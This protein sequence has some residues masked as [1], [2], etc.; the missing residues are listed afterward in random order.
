[1]RSCDGEAAIARLRA[2]PFV[3]KEGANYKFRI[4]FRVQHEIV[5]GLKFIN[6]V[7][8]GIFS[9]SGDVMLGSYAPQSAPHVFEFPRR[10]WNTAPSG[11]MFRGRYTSVDSYADSDGAGHLTYEYSFEIKK[12]WT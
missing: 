5:T 10:G 7:K 1:M 3:I 12:T 8:K 11:M 4:S 9:Q 2:T 6:K